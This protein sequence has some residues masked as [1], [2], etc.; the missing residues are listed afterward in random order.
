MSSRRNRRVNKKNNKKIVDET[1]IEVDETINQEKNI[2]L[3]EIHTDQD[4]NLENCECYSDKIFRI[5]Y[6]CIIY[7]CNMIKK[8]VNY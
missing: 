6:E 3:E 1:K 5:S 8:Y 4:A 2:L 7:I